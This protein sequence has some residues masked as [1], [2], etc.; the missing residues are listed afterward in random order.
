MENAVSYAIKNDFYLVE[1]LIEE[2]AFL[3]KALE[4]TREN[5]LPEMEVSSAHGKFLYLLAKIKN[6]SRILELGT[7]CGYS[8][9]WLAKA[10]SSG[11]GIIKT[12]EC[13]ETYANIAQ[14]NIKN[15]G[16]QNKVKILRGDAAELLNK[17]IL[18]KE[19][20]FDM[21]FIDADKLNYPKYLEL[22]LQ[23]STSGTIIYG[24]N[25]LRGGKLSNVSNPDSRGEGVRKFIEDLGKTKTLESTVLQTVGIKGFDGFSLSIVK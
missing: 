13:N 11:N 22:S 8:T 2:D 25:V 4:T 19:E 15:A 23:L 20:P 24:D 16:L 21:I 7:Y 3:K 12:I 5:N 9:I 1:N 10:L 6:A 14:K 18:E 17:L